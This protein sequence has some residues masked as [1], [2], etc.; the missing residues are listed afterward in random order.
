MR[1]MIA[2]GLLLVF[3]TLGCCQPNSPQVQPMTARP[4]QWS[5]VVFIDS[6]LNAHPNP[7]HVRRGAWVL[8]L[9]TPGAGE[10][11]IQGDFL[12]QQG[13]EGEH[14]WGHVR[15]DAT[16]GEHH[17]LARNLRPQQKAAADP[18]VMI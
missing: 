10:L 11:D 16:L 17:Y 7:V 4:D 1:R 13:H 14:A 18:E 9:L 6:G 2:P 12:E 3:L 5:V 8:F 15:S